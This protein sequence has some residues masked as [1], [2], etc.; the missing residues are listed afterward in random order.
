MHLFICKDLVWRSSIANLPTLKVSSSIFCVL[1]GRLSFDP[2]W[3]PQSDRDES[4]GVLHIWGNSHSLELAIWLWFIRKHLD[5]AHICILIHRNLSEYTHIWFQIY[6]N[7]SE[8]A[9]IWLQIYPKGQ[10]NQ[11]SVVQQKASNLSN[12]TKGTR[13]QSALAKQAMICIWDRNQERNWV[14]LVARL[15]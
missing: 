3:L 1:P 4:L 10:L 12:H 13:V 8:Y 2:A 9:H 14:L 5:Y 11:P 6:L 15:H 7:T